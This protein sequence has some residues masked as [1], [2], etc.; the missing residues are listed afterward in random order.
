MAHP[1]RLMSD[2]QAHT[3]S[4]GAA[5][6]LTPLRERVGLIYFLRAGDE[7]PVKIGYVEHDLDKRIRHLQSGHYEKLE[8]LRVI[9][10][11]MVDEGRFHLYFRERR[12]RGE[13]FRFD[14]TMLSLMICD[15]PR[16][17]PVPVLLVPPQP[18]QMKPKPKPPR[19]VA[20]IVYRPAPLKGRPLPSVPR[21]SCAEHGAVLAK[22]PLRA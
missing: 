20:P 3:I 1:C 21:Y 16:A 11:T 17:A 13:W 10:G 5:R 7:G 14:Q 2:V 6:R 15:L 8:L 9:P 4:L 19:P 12:I 18:T 22:M